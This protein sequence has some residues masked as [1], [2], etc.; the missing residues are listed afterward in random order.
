MTG[1]GIVIDHINLNQQGCCLRRVA[2]FD[3]WHL[4]CHEQLLEKCLEFIE[5]V[6]LHLD[7][8]NLYYHNQDVGHRDFDGL[9]IARLEPV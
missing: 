5:T 9:S 8:E 7:S 6:M 1:T 4:S 2:G 3:P